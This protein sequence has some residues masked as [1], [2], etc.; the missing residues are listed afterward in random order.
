MRIAVRELA[1]PALTQLLHADDDY[2]DGYSEDHRLDQ[3]GLSACERE[4]DHQQSDDPGAD[5]G[6]GRPT[7]LIGLVIGHA[8]SLRHVRPTAGP[9]DKLAT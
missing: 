9:P 4:D 8:V 6:V 3:A 7:R 5:I 2:G 1:G